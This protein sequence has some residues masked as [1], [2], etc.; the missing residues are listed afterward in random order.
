M[1]SVKVSSAELRTGAAN[2]GIIGN[3]IAAHPV[4]HLAVGDLGH[5]GV[6]AAL[7]EFRTAWVAEFHR[8]KQGTEQAAAVLTSAASDTERLDTLLA[9][10]ASRVTR[11]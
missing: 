4:H 6:A 5:A 8:R 9:Q 11:A 10:A 3:A 2:A 7:Q 1:S